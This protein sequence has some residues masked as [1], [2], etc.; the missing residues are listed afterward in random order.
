MTNEDIVEM[1]QQDLK[2]ERKHLAFYTQAAV[3]LK[4]LHREELRKF[5]E[6]EAT[7]ELQHVLQFSELIVHLGGTP[8]TVVNDYPG[9]L[10]AAGKIIDYIIQM[11]DDVAKNYANR[12]SSLN[13]FTPECIYVS[14]FYTRQLADSWR[15][16]REVEQMRAV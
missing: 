5:C 16:A 12:V 1:L 8:G 15:T 7:E 2:N 10:T 14:D 3:T 13:E 6:A 9:N 11:E 4:G